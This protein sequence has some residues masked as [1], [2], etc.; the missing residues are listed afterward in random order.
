MGDLN[1]FNKNNSRNKNITV[2]DIFG[3]GLK[4]FPGIGKSTVSQLIKYFKSY[5]ALYERL[6]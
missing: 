3:L 1:Q 5:R 4:S 2:E 6:K